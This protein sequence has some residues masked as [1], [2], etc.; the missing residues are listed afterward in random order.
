MYLQEERK[1]WTGA[2]SNNPYCQWYWGNEKNREDP[3]VPRVSVEDAKHAK[4]LEMISQAVDKHRQNT[5]DQNAKLTIPR[6]QSDQ[7]MWW[8]RKH[9][10]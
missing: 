4:R 1:K 3:R 7:D 8:V 6:Y 2:P 10:I 5:G 9:T